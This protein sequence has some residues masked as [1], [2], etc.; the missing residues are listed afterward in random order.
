M[1]KF[2]I[3]LRRYVVEYITVNKEAPTEKEAIA[4]AFAE[5]VPPKT[6]ENPTGRGGIGFWRGPNFT[7]NP[8]LFEKI[9]VE[10]KTK[11]KELV[12]GKWVEWESV[13]QVQVTAPKDVPEVEVVSV[14]HHDK[15]K[16][17]LTLPGK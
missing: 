1:A 5:A 11:H 9:A 17:T 14:Y 2:S 6:P 13:E 7:Q 10:Q 3:L 16:A 4:L 12:D 15:K 8:E